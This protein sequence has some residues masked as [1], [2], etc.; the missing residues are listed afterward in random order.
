MKYILT[1]YSIRCLQLINT[2]RASHCYKFTG[3]LN[4]RTQICNK[5]RD[6][7]YP[8]NISYN[9]SV[10]TKTIADILFS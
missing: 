2:L 1:S 5:L 10:I 8:R 7:W 3:S 6:T 4:H 9:D